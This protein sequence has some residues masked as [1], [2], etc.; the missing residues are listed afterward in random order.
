[1][2]VE[3]ARRKPRETARWLVIC[4][5]R[6]P[7]ETRNSRNTAL[8]DQSESILT[9]GSATRHICVKKL[10][11]HQS[12][13]PPGFACVTTKADRLFLISSKS[14]RSATQELAHQK[15]SFYQLFSRPH[16]AP[17]ASNAAT[18]RLRATST[19]H[20]FYSDTL[21]HGAAVKN[22][23]FINVSVFTG[24]PAPIAK[25]WRFDSICNFHFTICYLL[26]LLSRRN[27]TGTKPARPVPEHRSR[28]NASP[29]SLPN[30]M[31][32]EARSDV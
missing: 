27:S 32:V 22:S 5:D 10:N 30:L 17:A 12:L 19:G 4:L 28:V 7:P 13:T 18:K 11:S 16:P 8:R 31:C 29:H 15:L 3:V 23:L 26:S 9:Q 24:R 14:P 6:N 1:M 2:Q 20:R 21:P 25:A